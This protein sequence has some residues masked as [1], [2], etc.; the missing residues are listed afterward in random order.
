MQNMRVGLIS[1]DKNMRKGFKIWTLPTDRGSTAPWDVFLQGLHAQ[2][3][4]PYYKGSPVR[5]GML[6]IVRLDKIRLPGEV[7]ARSASI[8]RERGE[9]GKEAD[10]GPLL[11]VLQGLY[12]RELSS[13]SSSSAGVSRLAE[14][15]REELREG[16]RRVSRQ[17]GS[18]EAL[19]QAVGR[20]SEAG[21]EVAVGLGY[22]VRATVWGRE[23]GGGRREEGGREWMLEYQQEG[24]DVNSKV[25]RDR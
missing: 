17:Y 11:S 6:G 7:K 4:T 22:R 20:G 16:L 24:G 23:E 3:F 21:G 19:V 10:A 2:S 15:E 8:L 13:S 9:V 25:E 5:F 12:E 18:V 14:G 1:E